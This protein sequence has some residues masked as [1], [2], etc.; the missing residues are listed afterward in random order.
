MAS[1]L[2]LLALLVGTTHAALPDKPNL[3]ANS[4]A[5]IWQRGTIVSSLGS[6]LTAYGPDMFKM[7]SSVSTATETASQGAG[8]PPTPNIVF[9]QIWTVGTAYTGGASNAYTNI[10]YDMDNFDVVPYLGKAMTLSFWVS[11]ANS[12]AHCVYFQNYTP[13]RNLV[14]QYTITSSNTWQYVSIPFQLDPSS[15]ASWGGN[16]VGI[17]GLRI[18]WNLESGSTYSGATSG[19]WGASQKYATTACAAINETGVTTNQ[20]ILTQVQLNEGSQPAPFQR[21]GGSQA[22][23]FMYAKHYYQTSFKNGTSSLPAPQ[24]SG[25]AAFVC[26]TTGVCGG[27]IHY[28]V[29]MGCPA[30]L[31][32]VYENDGT[33]QNTCTDVTAGSDISTPVAVAHSNLNGFSEITKTS[34]F[35]AAH[36]M[37]CNWTAQ[38]PL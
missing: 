27:G 1:Y 16:T 22:A 38:C 15:V 21:Y 13:N 34:A 28:A 33:Q 5:D 25:E 26:A 37:L 19:V 4:L 17:P 14:V 18:G 29:P 6:S 12:G 9:Y 31:V 32:N 24:A 3:I 8:S 2:A 36:V 30:P 35:T 20:F 11:A 23:E 7:V 10:E